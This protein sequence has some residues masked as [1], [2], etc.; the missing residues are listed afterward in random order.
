[1]ETLTIDA[2][3]QAGAPSMLTDLW[4]RRTHLS[5]DEMISIYTLVKGALRTY[6]PPELQ[7]LREDKEELVAQFIYSKVLRLEPGRTESHSGDQSAPSSGYAVCTYFRRFLIDCL[8][9][10]SY[11]RD[12]SIEIDGVGQQVDENAHAVDDPVESV[13]IQYGLDETR[14]R[15]QARAFIA[16]LDHYERLVLSGTLGEAAG[17]KGG[18]FGIA[19]Q[20]RIPSYHYRAV[21]LGVTLKKSAQSEDFAPTKIGRWISSILG[22]EI[23]LD[24]QDAIL[25][26]LNLL[27]VESSQTPA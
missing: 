27:A 25:I 9:S 2:A 3:V 19:A 12:I 26:V 11:Q 16:S 7:S 4:R 24:N 20:H 6:H 14:V 1:M 5:H 18:L 13:L 17:T 21:K 22:I 23:C 15:Q 8:R 10:A